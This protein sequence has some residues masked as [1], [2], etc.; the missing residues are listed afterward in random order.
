[1]TFAIVVWTPYAC[2]ALSCNAYAQIITFLG[3]ICVFRRWR[4]CAST[5]SAPTHKIWR[6]CLRQHS[7]NNT[8][9]RGTN[10]NIVTSSCPNNG[11]T[12]DKGPAGVGDAGTEAED[13]KRIRGIVHEKNKN[14][15]VSH[16]QDETEKFV[17]HDEQKL[18]SVWERWHW[19]DI[20]GGRLD[21]EL[22]AKARREEV[23][24]IR[25]HM[26]YTRVPRDVCLH[27]TERA[28]IN[29]GWAE[30]D[31]GHPGKPNVRARW[32]AKECKTHA[33]PESY[34]STPPLEALK[35]LS[36][37][38]TGDRGR[39]VVALVDVRQHSLHDTRDAAL[40]LTRG[41]A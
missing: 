12:V 37:I 39:K 33:R 14:K 18:L 22:C 40:K 30:T 27:K 20:R 3:G 7:T 34:A 35:E 38:A 2:R 24:Y 13:A 1:M 28:P 41:I 29:T 32:V 19:D 11:G 36:E 8:I 5:V 10:R 31:K 26:M 4:I 25:R 9:E 6:K 15:T 23:E 21:L 17:H 16:V